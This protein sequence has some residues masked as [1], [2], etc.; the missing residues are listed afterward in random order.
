MAERCNQ[1]F[2][3]LTV[4]VGGLCLGLKGHPEIRGVQLVLGFPP[5]TGGIASF[6]RQG[7]SVCRICKNTGNC[8]RGSGRLK[9]EAEEFHLIG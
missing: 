7:L 3:N 4:L 6:R 2:P 8:W 9:S 1:F 5:V